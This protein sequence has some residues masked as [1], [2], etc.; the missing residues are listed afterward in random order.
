MIEDSTSCYFDSVIVQYLDTV[1]DITGKG[2]KCQRYRHPPEWFRTQD[3]AYTRAGQMY[4]E[5]RLESDPDRVVDDAIACDSS[6]C[7]NNETGWGFDVLCDCN[8]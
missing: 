6:T 4:V 7:Q 3:E 8:K 1:A 2:W 5:A